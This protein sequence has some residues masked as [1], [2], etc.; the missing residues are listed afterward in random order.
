MTDPSEPTPTVEW[1][2]AP[3]ERQGFAKPPAYGYD[4]RDVLK[5]NPGRWAKLWTYEKK[6]TASSAA[7]SLRKRGYEAQS[8]GCDLYARW[9]EQG[10]APKPVR[11]TSTMTR[12][13]PKAVGFVCDHCDDEMDTPAALRHYVRREHPEQAA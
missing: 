13:R 8:N 2:E 10:E 7:G 4:V 1:V 6:G 3:P 12:A 5:A 9:P 11:R